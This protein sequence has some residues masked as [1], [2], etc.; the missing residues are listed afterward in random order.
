MCWTYSVLD[1]MTLT[2]EKAIELLNKLDSY[3]KDNGIK[4]N[5]SKSVRLIYLAKEIINRYHS[6]IL[7]ENGTRYLCNN[8][9]YLKKWARLESLKK[10]SPLNETKHLNYKQ[11]D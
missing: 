3:C 6:V 10:V 11:H 4:I 2:K 9:K 7:E 5:A 1:N 8:P